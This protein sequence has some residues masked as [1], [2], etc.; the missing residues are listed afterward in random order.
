MAFR[1]LYLGAA[2]F[3]AISV[4]AWV[5]GFNGSP[6]LPGMLWHG[7]EMIWGYAGAIVVG[8]LL[9]AGATWTGHKTLSGAPLA[10][11]VAIWFAARLAAALET[12]SPLPTGIL[13]VGFL[14]FA[15]LALAL[16]V[17]RSR[18]RRNYALVVLLLVF[19]LADALFLLATNG[20]LA[21]D[22]L[23]ILY[24]GLLLVSGFIG[25][26]GLR[27]IPFFTH[28][29]LQRP[30]VGHP[31]WLGFRGDRRTADPGRDAAVRRR[32]L[33]G[34]AGRP[35]G[36]DAQP[37]PAVAQRPPRNAPSSLIVGPFRR[38]QPDRDRIG[39]ERR[40]AGP[41]AIFM[42]DARRVYTIAVGGI[43]TLTLGMMTRTALGHTG[44]RLE[45]PA[46]QRSAYLLMLLATA[47]RVAAALPGAPQLLLLLAGIA[48]AGRWHCS[49]CAMAPGCSAH[50]P[51]ACLA[52]R[53]G[54]RGTHMGD[55]LN[56]QI[57]AERASG[58]TARPRPRER[59]SLIVESRLVWNLSPQHR[60]D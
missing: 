19:A 16:P 40:R 45:L 7:H 59:R 58:G 56:S 22:P 26:I 8:F 44:R 37:R 21:V 17:I 11:L 29:A 43:G 33:R 50:A 25:V 10:G 4:L 31:R 46:N 48:F 24:A 27:V 5:L 34:T 53:H 23:R 18:N 36:D 51:T 35:R 49:C 14:V 12:G 38:L 32:R 42:D 41:A 6:A 3:G 2:L 60:R 57:V 55:H 30:Q 47:L 15:A 1:P 9:T 13:S 20:R 52:E 28:R 54:G 39:P